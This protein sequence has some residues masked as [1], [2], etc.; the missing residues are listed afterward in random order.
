MFDL[1]IGDMYRGS[2]GEEEPEW[3]KNEKEQ[4]SLYRDKDRDGY[5][6]TDEVGN[7]YMAFTLCAI[8]LKCTD[9]KLHF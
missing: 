4:F 5:L 8:I 1:H 3:V 9:K 6:N 2:E 7:I